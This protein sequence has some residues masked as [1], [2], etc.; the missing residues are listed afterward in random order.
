MYPNRGGSIPRRRARQPSGGGGAPTLILPNFAKNCMTEKILG[1]GGGAPPPNP[2][3]PNDIY[4]LVHRL[5]VMIKETFHVFAFGQC[6]HTLS[7]VFVLDMFT[8][9]LCMCS[10]R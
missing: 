6:K 3:L 7:V 9:V 8:E 2:P 5:T 10:Y 1:R 4:C